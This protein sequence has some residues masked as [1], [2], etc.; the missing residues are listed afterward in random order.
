MGVLLRPFRGTG[1][2]RYIIFLNLLNLLN[3]RYINES[4]VKNKEMAKQNI[5]LLYI[6]SLY[7]EESYA[8]NT[9]WQLLM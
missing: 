7:V 1:S 3:H 6:L 4:Q 9:Q 5:K 8:C 2:P